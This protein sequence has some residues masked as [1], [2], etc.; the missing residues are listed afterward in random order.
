MIEPQYLQCLGAGEEEP[1]LAERHPQ[2]VCIAT[3]IY[4]LNQSHPTSASPGFL[5]TDEHSLSLTTITR[6]GAM[7]LGSLD[8]PRLQS[9]LVKFHVT[10]DTQ[11]VYI[12]KNI[13][14]RMFSSY[15]IFLVRRKFC[16][17]KNLWQTLPPDAFSNCSA[18]TPGTRK[19]ATEL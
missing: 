6:A 18:K 7:W 13:C 12:N 16:V 10:L 1:T 15:R 8:S 17:A 3:D 14:V 11:F 9:C 5:D 4:R 19:Y 2:F